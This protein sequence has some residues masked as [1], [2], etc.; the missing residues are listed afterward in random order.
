MV[1]LFDFNKKVVIESKTTSLE[2][3]IKT[4]KTPEEYLS[5][6]VIYSLTHIGSFAYIVRSAPIIS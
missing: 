2:P 4:Q 6:S 1:L 5:S 3:L